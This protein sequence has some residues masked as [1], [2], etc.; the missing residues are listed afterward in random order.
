MSSNRDSLVN[1]A[2]NKAADS[3]ARRTRLREFQSQLLARMQAARAGSDTRISQLGVIIGGQRWL[4]DLTEASEIVPVSSITPVPLTH[5]WYLGL[6]NIRG[7]LISVIDFARFQG[8]PPTPISQE[9][10]IIAFAPGLSFNSGLLVSRVLGLRNV[11]E[12][13]LHANTAENAQTWSSHCY[14]DNEATMWNILDLALL[15][16][17]NQFLHVGL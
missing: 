13:E 9:S 5:D 3:A 2:T 15:V 14:R 17:D 12:M 11:A 6:S 16:Q 4:L 10:R 1:K 8:L 7:N